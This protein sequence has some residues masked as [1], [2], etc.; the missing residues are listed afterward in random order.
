MEEEISGEIT[1]LPVYTG[2]CTPYTCTSFPNYDV[3]CDIS[4]MKVP[5]FGRNIDHTDRA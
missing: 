5:K 4:M 1:S 2:K 3:A